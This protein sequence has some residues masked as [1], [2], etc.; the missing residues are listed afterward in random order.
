MEDRLILVEPLLTRSQERQQS[1]E[2]IWN[3]LKRMGF[4]LDTV[5]AIFSY[6]DIPDKN[7][8]VQLLVKT[9]EGYRHLFIPSGGDDDVCVICREGLQEHSSRPIDLSNYNPDTILRTSQEEN[10]SSRNS[11]Q[12]V[13]GRIVCEICYMEYPSE[14][15]I[16]LPCGH[17]FCV[18]CIDGYLCLEIKEARVL[19]IKCCQVD[20][21]F[22]FDPEIIASIVSPSQYEKYL[23][24][25][26]NKLT[27]LDPDSKWCPNPK[28]GQ[29]VKRENSDSNYM[30]CADCGT[31]ICYECNEPW[32]PKVTCEKATDESY[33]AWA[34]GK[35]IQKCPNCKRRVEKDS[36]CNHM[37]C[38]VCGY[39]WCWLCRGKYTSAHFDR[40][41]PFGCPG[42]QNGDNTAENWRW[43]KRWGKKCGTLLMMVLAVPLCNLYIVLVF[44]FALILANRLYERTYNLTG[45]CR[46]L[47]CAPLGFI[48]GLILTPI[49]DAIVIVVGPIYAVIYLIIY[50]RMQDED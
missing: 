30:K 7:L 32:H 17:M 4:D 8:A 44:W 12:A 10:K 21:E 40:F 23:T 26:R 34:R 14:S 33:E 20:C 46:A 13:D 16:S 15:V 41:N 45:C 37:T 11:I 36:G 28:C 38:A 29:V 31:E 42:L 43:Y 2:S 49:A 48:I 47:C 18:T 39:Q 6:Y 27:E 5:D 9:S 19:Q 50:K 24:F 1:Q 3:D 35:N 25:K 22:V